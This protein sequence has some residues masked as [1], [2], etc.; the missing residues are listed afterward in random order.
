MTQFK[1]EIAKIEK[2]MTMGI[3]TDS[4]MESMKTYVDFRKGKLG[5]SISSF[6]VDEAKQIL[7]LLK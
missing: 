2:A 6:V 5:G 1:D 7:N 3:W 4:S